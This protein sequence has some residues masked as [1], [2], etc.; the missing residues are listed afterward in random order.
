MVLFTVGLLP[1]AH[2]VTIIDAGTDRIVLPALKSFRMS[3]FTSPVGQNQRKGQAKLKGGHF[4]LQAVKDS[5][6]SFGFFTFEK[7]SSHKGTVVKVKR[8]KDFVTAFA[9]KYCVHLYD[10]RIR[11]ILQEVLIVFI[12]AAFKAAGIFDFC[13]MHMPDFIRHL[14]GEIDIFYRERPEINVVINRLLTES[15][16]RVVPEDC[17]WRLPL[18]DQRSYQFIQNLEVIF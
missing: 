9:S 3:E 5:F 16:F 4:L 7:E 15:E 8:E 6:H 1:G 14:L 12:S 13:L 2:R 17:I 11:M 18:P 10:A